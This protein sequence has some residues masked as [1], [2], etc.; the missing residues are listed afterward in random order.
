MYPTILAG[1]LNAE[2]GSLPIN[3]LEIIWDSSYDRVSPA[4]TFPS[5]NPVKKID[6]V[7]HFPK[8]KWRVL[9]SRV[10]CDSVASDH[11]A[12]LVTLELIR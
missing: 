8:G 10:I 9:D 11:C 1:D 4:P 7:M 12:Y 3:I 5:D 2:P 6:Y